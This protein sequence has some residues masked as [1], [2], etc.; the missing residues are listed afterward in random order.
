MNRRSFLAGL[1]GASAA[2]VAPAVEVPPVSSLLK[3][4]DPET[5]WDKVINSIFR[6]EILEVKPAYVA[7]LD[8]NS[9]EFNPVTNPWYRRTRAEFAPA[10]G[11]TAQLVTPLMYGPVSHDV[12]ISQVAIV[13][14]SDVIFLSPV[15]SSNRARLMAREGDSVN[16]TLNVSM[17]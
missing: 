12:T 11:G 4:P 16:V 17:G 5:F 6:G 3:D 15:Y 7:L 10:R 8:E 1:I 13:M 14:G 2:L 9:C